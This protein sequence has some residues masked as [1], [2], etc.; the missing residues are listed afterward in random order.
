M[1]KKKSIFLETWPKYDPQLV[2]DETIT[3]VIQ[4]NGKLRDQ[5]DVPVDIS[6]SKAKEMALSREKIKKWTEGKEIKKII[7][8][9][10]KLVNIVV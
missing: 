5:I 4:I 1:G 7:F 9:A 2:Q 6:E 8:I 3:L 10:G